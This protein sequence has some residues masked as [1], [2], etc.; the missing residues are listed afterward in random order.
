M[1]LTASSSAGVE[2]R[3]P[4]LPARGGLT[5]GALD[6]VARLHRQFN[7]ERQALLAARAERQQRFDAGELPDFLSET[8]DVREGEWQVAPITTADLQKRWVELTG[9]TER[10]M[11]INALNSGADV[12][13]AD[14]E[15]ANTPSWS[16]MLDGQ[17]N[18]VDA[19][20]EDLVETR[21]AAVQAQRQDGHAIGPPARLAPA[22]KTL[23]GRWGAGRRALMDFG[24][25][26]LTRR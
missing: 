23:P 17:I 15:D 2:V 4:Q 6:F 8:Q 5:P 24:L 1:S 9:P 3:A 10:K 7:A 26:F 18:L 19:I 12:Y 22:R 14:F 20:M 25:A 21:W 13:M 11:L 16:N